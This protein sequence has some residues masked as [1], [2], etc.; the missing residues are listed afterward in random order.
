[1]NNKK[2]MIRAFIGLLCYVSF[3]KSTTTTLTLSVLC[4]ASASF[5]SNIEASEHALSDISPLPLLL[6]LVV[7]PKTSLFSTNLGGHGGGACSFALK[8]I[9]AT[10]HAVSLDTTSQRP[11]LASIKQS[12]SA[13][14]SIIVT[15]GSQLTYG[16]R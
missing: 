3:L 11:S 2:E 15:S 14:R 13:V 5:V 7:I 12:S 1:M 16:F 6:L 9:R 8:H 10:P 4:L